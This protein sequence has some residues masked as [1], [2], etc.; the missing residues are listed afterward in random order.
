MAYPTEPHILLTSRPQVDWLKRQL[1]SVK[2]FSFDC[3]T[4]GPGEPWRTRKKDMP[5]KYK[6]QMAGYSLGW[7]NGTA[8]QAVY[9]PWRHTNGTNAKF[10]D[11]LLEHVVT[12]IEARMWCHNY[13]YD[14][15]IIRNELGCYVDRP[16]GCTLVLAAFIGEGVPY[17]KMEAGKAKWKFKKGLKDLVL[18]KYGYQM[19]HFKDVVKNNVTRLRELKK[20]AGQLDFGD[21]VAEIAK[22]APVAQDSFEKLSPTDGYS[23]ACDDALWCDIIRTDFTKRAEEMGSLG[24]FYDTEMPFIQVLREAEDHG[25]PVDK[26]YLEQFSNH[27]Q[28]KASNL[29]KDLMDLLGVDPNRNKKAVEFFYGPRGYFQA[30]ANTMNKSGS[31]SMNKKAISHILSSTNDSDKAHQTVKKLK[32]YRAINT[33]IGHMI[34]PIIAQ[35]AHTKSDY[36]R[37]SLNPAVTNTGRISAEG[38]NLTATPKTPEL[39]A[40]FKAP[41]GYEFAEFD[42]SAFEMV[43]I[44]HYSQDP[45]IRRVVLDG[46][47]MHDLTAKM[48]EIERQVAKVVNLSMLYGATPWGLA[49]SLGLPAYFDDETGNRIPHPKAEEVYEGFK[50]AYAGLT[51]YTEMSI[52]YA[53][54][55]GGIRTLS[56]RFRRLMDINSD[57]SSRRGAAEREA[58]NTPIQGTAAD[59]MKRAMVRIHRQWKKSGLDARMILQVHDSL[60]IQ[61]KEELRDQVREDVTRAMTECVKLRLPLSVSYKC[62]KTW[63]DVK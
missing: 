51:K 18:H 56:G 19:A 15:R 61:Y 62:G 33:R 59:I 21:V 13:M 9:V 22:L 41:V 54:K 24:W 50:K 7:F 23:Y 47:S 10:A 58:A 40:M 32:E 8:H 3:E 4:F 44:G 6:A 43:I 34:R 53:R 2:D 48:L 35:L 31:L 49:S 11:Q 36:L 20:V 26:E 14:G 45:E 52:L 57:N 28:A 12:Q 60:L 17:L 46:V 37:C 27:L 55:H 39:R 16:W 42:F 1:Y 25:L 38:P 29:K 5:D 30:N 63:A